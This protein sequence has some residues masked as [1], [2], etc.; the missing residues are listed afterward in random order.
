MTGKV[1]LQSGARA[2]SGGGPQPSRLLQGLLRSDG[3]LEFAP[4]S[5]ATPEGTRLLQASGLG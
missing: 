2:S 3:A 1:G 5:L 4:T